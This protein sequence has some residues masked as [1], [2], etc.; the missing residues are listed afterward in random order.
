VSRKEVARELNPT[1]IVLYKK[2]KSGYSFVYLGY[3]LGNE[4]EHLGQKSIHIWGFGNR[5]FSK[6]LIAL[7]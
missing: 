6:K 2:G 3:S 7:A 4:I 1:R 5:E